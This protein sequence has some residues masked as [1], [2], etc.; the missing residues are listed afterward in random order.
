MFEEYVPMNA[1][2]LYPDFAI[3]KIVEDLHLNRGVMFHFN[4][5]YAKHSAVD[6]NEHL[7]RKI[8]DQ[9]ATNALE[10]GKVKFTRHDS[11]VTGASMV[12][13]TII[14]TYDELYKLLRHFNIHVKSTENT[15]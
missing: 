12:G 11:P 15:L 1:P 13:E 14:M 6:Y 8:A 7:K 2:K 5:E 10:D 9:L 3:K 4:T